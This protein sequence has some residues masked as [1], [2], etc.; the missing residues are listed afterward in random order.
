MIISNDLKVSKAGCLKELMLN[1]ML[2]TE[3]TKRSEVGETVKPLLIYIQ[4]DSINKMFLFWS[5]SLHATWCSM[6]LL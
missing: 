3:Q 4:N 1:S 5:R 6:L 2:E